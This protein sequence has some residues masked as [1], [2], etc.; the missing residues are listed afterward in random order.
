[1]D[2]G[3]DII[4]VKVFTFIS[5]VFGRIHEYTS[6][7]FMEKDSGGSSTGGKRES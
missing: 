7:C 4:G 5:Y 3:A 2:R 1:M 6:L